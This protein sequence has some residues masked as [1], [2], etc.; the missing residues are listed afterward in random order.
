MIS[1][2]ICDVNEGRKQ[3]DGLNIEYPSKPIYNIGKELTKNVNVCR[4]YRKNRGWK[5]YFFGWCIFID[6]GVRTMNYEI[7]GGSL[8]VALCHLEAGEGLICEAGAMS[9]MDD[10][11]EMKTEGGGFG[12]MF[13]RMFS[14]ESMFRNRYIAKASGE[15]AFAS[16]FPGDILPVELH[17]NSIIF[18]K[19]SFLVSDEGIETSVHFQKKLGA[20][21]FGGEGFI[22]EK[23]V[24]EGVVLLEVDGSIKEYYLEAGDKKII[25]TGHLVMM[26]ETCSMDIVSVKGVKN[27]LLGGEGLFNTVVTGPGR[28]VLQTMPMSKVA[29]LLYAMMPKSN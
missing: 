13:G 26:D 10:E 16:K 1:F 3:Y 2:V 25:D 23:A 19:K 5:P 17:G 27:V 15:I 14:G 9:W 6:K 21:F 4:L 28:I 8:P 7:I 22:M 20:G 18:Q 12:K 24:G 29:E 11:I